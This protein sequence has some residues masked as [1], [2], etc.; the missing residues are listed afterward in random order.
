MEQSAL[1]TIYFG[2]ARVD[3]TSSTP[4]NCSSLL[5][6]DDSLSVLRAKVIKKV[7]TDKFVTILSPNPCQTFSLFA[8][9]FVEVYAAGGAVTNDEGEL[10]MIYLRK[11]WDL[12]KGH[13]EQ[14]EDSAEAARREVLEET[15]IE[16]TV[17]GDKPL[18]TT[19]HAYDTYGRWELKYTDWWRMT[20][21]GGELRPQTEEGICGIGWYSGMGLAERLNSTYPTIKEVIGAL[22]L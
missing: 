22:K 12:P 19:L 10:L 17:V 2:D 6:V 16:A 18:I 5:V 15:G 9:Q 7:E 13:V 14:G 21:V 20:A 1:H 8:A 11:R 3:I 4:D